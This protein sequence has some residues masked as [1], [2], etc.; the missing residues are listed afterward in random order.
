MNS[1]TRSWVGLLVACAALPC[2]SSSPSNPSRPG[3]QCAAPEHRQFDFWVGDWDVFERAN[4]AQRVARAQVSL[5][6]DDCVLLEEYT[7]ADGHRGKSFSLYDGTTRSWRQTWVTNRGEVLDI[8]G[9]LDPV[10][11]MVL[12][13]FDRDPAGA[14]RQV[15]GRWEL[16]SG[17]RVVREIAERQVAGAPWITW[18]D[19]EFRP[20]HW[21]QAAS[22]VAA[23]PVRNLAWGGSPCALRRCALRKSRL[24]KKSPAPLRRRRGAP[25]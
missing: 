11:A 14:A 7:G 21:S 5:I 12:S 19:L 24:T 9:G 25:R 15:R 4:G 20:H 8:R 3:A 23:S 2:V 18:F 16:E 10:G 17:G 22:P 13:G 6:L 1:R